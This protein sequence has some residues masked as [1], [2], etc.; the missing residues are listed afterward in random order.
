[1]SDR[2]SVN[3]PSLLMS[4]IWAVS[5]NRALKHNLKHVDSNNDNQV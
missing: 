4:K 1:M 5:T 2:V 3:I